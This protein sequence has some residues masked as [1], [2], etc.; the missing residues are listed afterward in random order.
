VE[1]PSDFQSNLA[2]YNLF[3][4]ALCCGIVVMLYLKDSTT[5]DAPSRYKKRRTRLLL[6]WAFSGYR[7]AFSSDMAQIKAA[8]QRPGE[9]S[10]GLK[11]LALL[12][13]RT[14]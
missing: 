11:V 8:S 14:C 7:T 1:K 3:I 5:T 9:I 4:R 12:L 2:F 6:L 10:L 13:S